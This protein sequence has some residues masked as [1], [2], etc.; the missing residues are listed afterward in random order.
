MKIYVD[1]YLAKNLGDDLFI[2]ILTTRYPEHKFYAISKGEKGYNTKN[3]KY[4]YI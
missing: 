3:L 1:A 4:V 2:N